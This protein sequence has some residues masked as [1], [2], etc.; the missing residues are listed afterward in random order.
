[1]LQH[2]QWQWKEK[3]HKKF[4]PDSYFKMNEKKNEMKVVIRNQNKI[5]KEIFEMKA[6]IV[7]LEEGNIKHYNTDNKLLENLENQRDLV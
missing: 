6:R 7:L 5:M 3:H 2:C 4:T 1:M